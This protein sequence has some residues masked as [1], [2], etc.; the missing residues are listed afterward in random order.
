M[1]RSDIVLAFLSGVALIGVIVVDT[2]T[3]SIPDVLSAT[4][5]TLIGATA[6]VA[7][8]GRSDRNGNDAN[9]EPLG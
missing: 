1:M 7:V 4:L 6:G 5:T 9:G 2:L 8:S 3:G